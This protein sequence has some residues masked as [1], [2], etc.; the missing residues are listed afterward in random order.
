M[1]KILKKWQ[2]KAKNTPSFARTPSIQLRL[3]LA[4]SLA[5]LLVAVIAGAVS[6]LAIF[7]DAL[8]YQ[9]DMLAQTALL[10]DPRHPPRI[11]GNDD[12]TRIHIEIPG[13]SNFLLTDLR[14]GFHDIHY[15]GTHYRAYIRTYADAHRLA[16]VQETDF[17]EDA[18][19]A[20]AWY[21]IAPL[22][23]L[24]PL[25]ALI[26]Y[27]TIRRALQPVHALSHGVEKRAE[28]D[29]SPLPADNIPTEIRG[30]INALN[31]LLARTDQH[32]RNQR[33]FIADAAHELR[34]PLTAL[35]LQA[36]RLAASD[37]GE[38]A[39]ERL[40]VLRDGIRRNRHL[41]DQL[42]ALARAQNRTEATP[43]NTEKTATLR[44]LYRRI[45]E[46][47]HLQAAAKNL[48]LGIDG[49][50]DAPLCADEFSLYTLLRNIVD[51]A[52]RYTPENGQIDLRILPQA[53]HVVLEIEDSGPGI[54]REERGRVFESFYRS[55]DAIGE[56]S[57]LGLAIAE[58]LAAQLGA[59]I[60]LADSTR[61]P[62][63]LKVSIRLPLHSASAP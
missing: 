54:A 50:A 36:E 11:A 25:L 17:R 40:Q 51:N 63:G 16:F 53:S 45:I 61:F 28:S 47:L 62:S 7:D 46:E 19:Y 20:S 3:T 34:S 24:V 31:R 13:E 58:T 14:D 55:P 33:R 44:A 59:H 9:D 57:G 42:L 60:V 38:E 29:L 21:A 6:F 12:D 1:K 18:A 4:L 37:M 2:N 30:F 15:D 5:T 10:V 56:G 26:S 32:M 43:A 49:D 22:L 52:I 8:D 41:L 23:F 35:S 39:R 27:F 48:D